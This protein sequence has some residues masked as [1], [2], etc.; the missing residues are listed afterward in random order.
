VADLPELPPIRKINPPASAPDT[1]VISTTPGSQTETPIPPAYYLPQTAFPATTPQVFGSNPYDITGS[2]NGFDGFDASGNPVITG[3]SPVSSGGGASITSP[4][5][6][7]V[8]PGFD[9]VTG[10]PDIVL[11]DVSTETTPPFRSTSGTPSPGTV[12]TTGGTGGGTL[13]GGALTQIGAFAGNWVVRGGVIVVGIVLI[14]AAAWS[15]SGEPGLP[16]LAAKA[17][18]RAN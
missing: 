15:L 11:P 16:K 13:T 17:P 10:Q 12:P 18:L 6:A 3:N 5:P 7:G 14:A 8:A 4:L 1:F 2:P 9:P